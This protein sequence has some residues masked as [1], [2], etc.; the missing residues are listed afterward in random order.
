[1]TDVVGS[2]SEHSTE[3]ASDLI[4]MSTHGKGNAQRL[5]FGNLAQR[6]TARG[7]TPV[8]IVPPEQARGTGVNA[9]WRAILA[10][11]DAD[12]SYEKS[13]SFAANIALAFHCR[14]HLLM[15]VPTLAKLS[16]FQSAFSLFLPG[17]TSA[18]LG[19]ETNAA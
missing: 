9:D 13:L 11:I 17:T 5:L 19:I 18:K 6:V 10:P 4:V 1:M 2:I 12:P 3:L 7:A 14:L 16:G 15:V 8:L